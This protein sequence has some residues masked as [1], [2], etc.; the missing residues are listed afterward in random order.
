MYV[1]VHGRFVVLCVCP[2]WRSVLVCC[3]MNGSLGQLCTV[4][5]YPTI[6]LPPYSP[7]SH[8]TPANCLFKVGL[9]LKKWLGAIAFIGAR[10]AARK[11]KHSWETKLCPSPSHVTGLIGYHIWYKMDFISIFMWFVLPRVGICQLSE[12]AT[13][14]R[15]NI[16]A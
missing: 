13:W 1:V 12:R 8:A 3:R 5:Q 10:G 9:V 15:W 11:N 14:R 6:H 2:Q 7:P 4:T 16:A